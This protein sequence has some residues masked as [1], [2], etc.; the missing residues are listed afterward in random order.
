VDD[1]MLAL[2][3]NGHSASYLSPVLK[4]QRAFKRINGL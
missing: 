1:L 3:S 4:Q 2:I